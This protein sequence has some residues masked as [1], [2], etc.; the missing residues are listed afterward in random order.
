MLRRRD[1]VLNVL[2]ALAM[3]I[4][5]FAVVAFAAPF[6]DPAG[7]FSTGQFRH[8]GSPDVGGAT[9][10]NCHS[11]AETAASVV[12]DV[13]TSVDVGETT[14][15]TVTI[16]GGPAALAG[17]NLAASGLAGTLTPIDA[18][19]QLS[20]GEISHTTPVAFAGGQA[21]F[22]FQWTAPADP[23]TVSLYVS[24]VSADGNAMNTGDAVAVSS[25]AV[26]VAAAPTPT[27]TAAP[28]QTDADR[29]ADAAPTATPTPLPQV[30][31]VP[32]GAYGFG[33]NPAP[34]APS[35]LVPAAAGGA[36]AAASTEASVGLAATGS[37]SG[38]AA[39]ISAGLFAG[40]AL[41]VV[42]GRRRQ[43]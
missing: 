2:S 15:V 16:S 31:P 28:Q 41:F 35:A 30:D 8:S 23:S 22:R 1:P 6:A 43:R 20:A 34:S 14:A 5:L 29:A 17:F 42:A 7:A 19:T 32:A 11:G 39:T 24:A 10:A 3:T 12:L 37:T 4:V 18:T 21:T 27:P 26:V 33:L 9:C 13:P 40:G 36:V 38:I 25:A